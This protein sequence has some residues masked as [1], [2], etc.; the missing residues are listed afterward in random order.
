MLSGIARAALFGAAAWHPLLA[1]AATFVT[2]VTHAETALIAVGF[3]LASLRGQ[4]R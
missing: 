2:P 1:L 3:I 4:H